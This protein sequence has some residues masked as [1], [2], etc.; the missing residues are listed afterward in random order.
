MDW[1]NT[2]DLGPDA[3]HMAR[4]PISSDG[5]PGSWMKYHNGIFD[6]P[7]LGGNSTPVINRAN[8]VAGFAG[9]PN[10][11][12]NTFLNQYIAIVTGHDG[13]SYALS[14][15]GIK[16]S[17]PILFSPFLTHT[18]KLQPGDT[19]YSYAS[20]ISPSQE[21]HVTTN[22]TAYLYYSRGVKDRQPHYMVRR[23]L[24]IGFKTNLPLVFNN[25][26]NILS[27]CNTLQKNE[28]RL[29]APNSF[30]V[31]DIMIDNIKQYDFGG[32]EE[33]TVAF[34]ERSTSV[35][36]EWG[37]ACYI[38]NRNLGWQLIQNEFTHGYGI[39][40]GCAKVR[41]VIVKLNGQQ[42]VKCHYPDGRISDLQTDG[43]NT[44]C[45]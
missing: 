36:A 18:D 11:S 37:A 45:P 33:G 21:T 3:I 42:E 32:N 20:L 38:G 44:W 22:H 16:W 6:E 2:T 13:F 7:G 25:F 39:E 10:V 30:V 26:S 24:Q 14:S 1:W 27:P 29:I 34:F 31:G 23:P 4:A 35:F 40:S 17:S 8:V 12:F 28:I 5:A 41:Y 19:W 43:N 15:N 9:N